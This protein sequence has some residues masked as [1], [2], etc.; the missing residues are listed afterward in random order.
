MGD[1]LP[2]SSRVDSLTRAVFILAIVLGAFAT[3]PFDRSLAAHELASGIRVEVEKN[4]GETVSGELLSLSDQQ[5]LLQSD[6]QPLT[7]TADQIATVEF[8]DAT[9]RSA[10]RTRVQLRNGSLVSARSVHLDSERLT[11]RLPR[12][13]AFE[14]DLSKV[15]SVRLRGE[16]ARTDPVWLGILGQPSRRDKLV[17]R[18]PGEKLDVIEGVVLGFTKDKVQFQIDGDDISAPIEK[19]EGVVFGGPLLS[20]SETTSKRPPIQVI[21]TYGSRWIVLSIELNSHE[22]LSI[23]IDDSSTHSIPFSLIHSIHWSSGRVLLANETP[24][25][26]NFE[27]QEV[28]ADLKSLMSQLFGPQANGQSDLVMRG[29][30]R[31]VYRIEKGFRRATGSVQFDSRVELA[32]RLTVQI[33]LDDEVVW[34]QS[35]EDAEPLGFN[36]D[37]NQATRIE[38]QVLSEGEGDVGTTVRW[39]Q[40][41]L[42]K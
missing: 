14:M 32:G 3:S 26:S 17:I 27:T 24:A 16:S 25:D 22:E 18:R 10:L 39:I 23:H 19:L 28:S 38:F 2:N 36:I 13:S 34:T 40:P 29:N 11:I 6:G 7:I 4:D 41:K 12:Q 37:L 35:L 31:A 21:D 1:N 33:E 30:S 42:T 5:V 20:G 9:I 8:S 15:Q